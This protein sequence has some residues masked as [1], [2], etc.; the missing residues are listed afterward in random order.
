M[1]YFNNP[2]TEEELKNQFRQLLIKYDYRNPK[3]EKLISAI[4]KEYDQ[5]LLQIK[6]ANGYQTT[7]DKMTNAIKKAEQDRAN[8]CQRITNLKNKR[9]TKQDL[10][11]LLDEEKRYIEQ[12][13]RSA[14]HDE[15]V[16]YLSLKAKAGMEDYVLLYNFFTSN[17]ILLQSIV[18][19]DTFNR[20][21]EEI[22]YAVDYLSQNKRHF[23]NVMTQ[24]ETMMGKKIAESIVKYEELYLDPISIQETDKFYRR[25]TLGK[26]G[27]KTIGQYVKLF[28]IAP[29][30]AALI[31]FL[32]I[33]FSQ[34]EPA[35]FTVCVFILIYIL[36]IELWDRLVVR[37]LE[38]RKNRVRTQQQATDTGKAMGGLAH[39]ISSFLR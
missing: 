37:P 38:K 26:K 28:L 29:A 11:N 19:A 17:S 10:S 23:E 39:L 16:V 22:E 6:R 3:N 34:N 35:C 5:T 18:P 12:I 21:R 31:I 32:D 8:E 30:L 24:V 9:Y 15:S 25:T 20:V 4:R 14:V 27:P 33:G 7:R 13:V 2:R 36:V 1:A